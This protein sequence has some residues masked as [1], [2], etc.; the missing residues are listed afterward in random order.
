MKTSRLLLLTLAF[1]GAIPLMVQGKPPTPSPE[2]EASPYEHGPEPEQSDLVE[3]PVPDKAKTYT[4]KILHFSPSK[5]AMKAVSTQTTQPNHVLTLPPEIKDMAMCGV[6]EHIAIQCMAKIVGVNFS[7]LGGGSMAISPPGITDYW[8][9]YI[10]GVLVGGQ[11]AP[12][13]P[14][15][16]TKQK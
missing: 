15:K 11:P 16:K 7:T 9:I 13:A 12:N 2:P 5:D 4:V 14:D 10:P 6:G 3:L 8:V 1:I